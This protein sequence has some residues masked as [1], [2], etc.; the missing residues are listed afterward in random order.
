MGGESEGAIMNWTHGEIEGL[1]AAVE[2]AIEFTRSVMD[3]EL[4]RAP[5]RNWVSADKANYVAWSRE[6]QGFQRLH[7]K[8]SRSENRLEPGH[9]GR[10]KNNGKR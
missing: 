3:A 7:R 6:L 9:R 5:D 10:S 1:L 2:R 4:P 8:L